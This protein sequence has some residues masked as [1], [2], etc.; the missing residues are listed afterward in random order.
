MTGVTKVSIEEWSSPE[1]IAVINGWAMAGLTVADIAHNIG[2]AKKTLYQWI[3]QN[4]AI[5][6]ALKNGRDVADQKVVNALYANALKGD[7]TAQIFWLKNRKGNDW[8]DKQD[9][10]I[11]FPQGDIEVSV[12]KSEDNS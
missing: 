6:N 1:N 2:I 4:I 10:S 11:D 3:K 9:H 8:R 12:K 7:T 5:C